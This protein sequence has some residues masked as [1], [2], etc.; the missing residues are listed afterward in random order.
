MLLKDM[1]KHSLVYI[2]CTHVNLGA[3]RTKRLN[4]IIKKLSTEGLNY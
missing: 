3:P 2:H 1:V 4:I